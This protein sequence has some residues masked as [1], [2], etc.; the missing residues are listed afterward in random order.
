MRCPGRETRKTQLR[1]RNLSGNPGPARNGDEFEVS[2]YCSLLRE[3]DSLAAIRADL[4]S[5]AIEQ[6]V[7]T[8]GQVARFLNRDS[9]AL[10]RLLARQTTKPKSR[11]R[12]EW[13][14][15]RRSSADV[16]LHSRIIDSPSSR[17]VFPASPSG[18]LHR[19]A[20]RRKIGQAA[21]ARHSMSVGQPLRCGRLPSYLQRISESSCQNRR[22]T[23]RR[24]SVVKRRRSAGTNRNSS[25][26]RNGK[27][28]T[29]LPLRDSSAS[30]ASRRTRGPL[31]SLVSLRIDTVD[32]RPPGWKE[33]SLL[34]AFRVGSAARQVPDGS[35]SLLPSIGDDE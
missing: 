9:S 16:V 26:R 33:F 22:T 11:I 13:N 2:S 21:G 34:R 18:S 5:Q 28:R 29:S 17:S 20:M 35:S 10:G 23:N 31:Q 15:R 19:F 6:R 3:R 4:V 24:R 12:P 7:A 8:L 27:T 25:G 1:Y 32:A 14:A 30:G